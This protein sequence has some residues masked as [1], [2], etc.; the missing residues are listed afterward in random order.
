M[1]NII[2]FFLLLFFPFPCLN[3]EKEKKNNPNK[4]KDDHFPHFPFL[5][6]PSLQSKPKINLKS[7]EILT[8]LTCLNAIS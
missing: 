5:F 3:I 1:T 2:I 8:H 4:G 6:P 7:P